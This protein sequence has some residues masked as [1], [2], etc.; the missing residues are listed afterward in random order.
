MTV[1]SPFILIFMVIAVV[2]IEVDTDDVA[3][4]CMV[5]PLRSTVRTGVVVD[6]VLVYS[7]RQPASRNGCNRVVGLTMETD[8]LYSP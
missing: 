3:S 4:A 7:Y 1:A 6:G 8:E 2:W 5:A